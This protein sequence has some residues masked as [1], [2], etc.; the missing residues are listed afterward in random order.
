MTFAIP[1]HSL[2]LNITGAPQPLFYA[3][4]TQKDRA[5]YLHPQR[6]AASCGQ[7]RPR[8]WPSLLI[9]SSVPALSMMLPCWSGRLW[10]GGRGPTHPW[11]APSSICSRIL[12]SYIVADSF[13]LERC[14]E[15]LGRKGDLVRWYRD[16]SYS[17]EDCSAAPAHEARAIPVCRKSGG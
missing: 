1:T 15:A 13:R 10:R 5:A 11:P 3:G 14:L 4:S 2:I 6:A 17:I 8:H 9:T 7:K 12:F 16:Q